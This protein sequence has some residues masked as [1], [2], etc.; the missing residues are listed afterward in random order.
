MYYQMSYDCL[1]TLFNCIWY[2]W[3]SNA[4]HI[5]WIQIRNHTLIS[6]FLSNCH[7]IKLRI[8]LDDITGSSYHNQHDLLD[9][10][11]IIS[12]IIG[13]LIN[14]MRKAWAD[15]RRGKQFYKQSQHFQNF[16]TILF[17]ITI[18]NAFKRVQTCLVRVH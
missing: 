18:A 1:K 13:I 7:H 15:D 14:T 17:G 8:W 16:L 6:P 12:V 11:G 9:I 10:L 3:V 4:Y 5:A 2:S